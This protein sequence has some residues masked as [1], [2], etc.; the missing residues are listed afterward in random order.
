MIGTY[1]PG[2]GGIA[3]TGSIG[4]ETLPQGS[5]VGSS[6]IASPMTAIVSSP[7]TA[8]TQGQQDQDVSA[9]LPVNQPGEAIQALKEN[10]YVFWIFI[11]VVLLA[12]TG[13]FKWR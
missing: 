9:T 4:P 11:A 10:P 2:Y 6:S 3:F 8:V 12:V 5:S 7:R 1:S 13:Q